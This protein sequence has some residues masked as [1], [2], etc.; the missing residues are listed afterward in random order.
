[1]PALVTNNFRIH[2][3]KQF[4]EMLSEASLYG[5]A[6]ASTALSTNAYLFIGKSD[7]WSGSFSD[8]SVP[9]PTTSANPS[10]DTTANTS[11]THWKDMI[12]AKKISSSDVSHVITRHNWTSGRVYQ[13]YK[14]TETMSD[15]L[16]TRTGQTVSNAGGTATE[17]ASTYPMYVMNTNY[18]VYKCL[19]NA[20][21][22]NQSTSTHINDGLRLKKA[23]ITT[24][25]KCVPPGDTPLKT[26]LDNS[27]NFFNEEINKLQNLKAIV[28]LGKIA[29][30]A[31]VYFY[32]S[33]YNFVDKVNFGHDKIYR[34]PNN[35]LLIGCY[36]PSPR[37]VN[38]GRINEQK[39]TNLFKKVLKMV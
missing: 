18:G 22:S 13:M 30:D 10:S 34:L 8:T 14:D 17:S 23:F 26:E 12:A 32:K 35:T 29:F 39:M 15:L 38:T 7:A 11:Y 1:M 19:Y 25:L 37:N 20:K 24:A 5:G 28:A 16:S 6:T 21:I 4:R 31:C 33:N 2:N 3:A 36:H 27:L 9:D